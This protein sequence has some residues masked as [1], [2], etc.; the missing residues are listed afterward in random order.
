M[1]ETPRSLGYRFPAEW[2]PHAAT[3][4]AWPRNPATWPGIFAQI[5]GQFAQFARAVA[6]FEPVHILAAGETAARSA[7]QYMAGVARVTIHDIP[8]NDSWIRDFGP[9]F[10]VSEDPG[11]PKALVDWG[12]NAWGGKYPPF[13][14]DNAVPAEIARRFAWH[15][16]HP[17]LV[18]EGGSIDGNGQGLLLTTASCLLHPSRNPGLNR[19]DIEW[20]L[21]HYLMIDQVIWLAGEIAGDDT[22]GHIDQLARFV[23]PRTVVHAFEENSSD[24][25]HRPLAEL[26]RMLRQVR[27]SDGEPLR[28][29]R[30]PMPA[31]VYHQERRVPACYANFYIVNGAVIV[32]QFDDPADH[33]ALEI[34]GELI[35]DRE[36]VGAPCRDLIWG[37]GAFHCLSQ[38]QP[39]TEEGEKALVATASG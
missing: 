24:V 35:A 30:L 9:T 8:T 29:V 11:R 31:P 38:Q 3:W 14:A 33:R 32:P 13:D 37:L 12:Y 39:G 26:E 17:G 28:L 4:L 27:L 1:A 36:V 16:F 2:E 7:E 6:R 20:Y 34:L 25:N 19:A 23:A 18:L 22:D 21:R 15:R 10:L 5:P